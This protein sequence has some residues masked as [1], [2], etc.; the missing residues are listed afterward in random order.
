MTTM[1][2]ANRLVELIKAGQ[3]STAMSELYA[4]DIVSIEAGGEMRESK[5]VEACKGKAEWFNSQFTNN[6]VEIMGPYPNDDKFAIHLTYD[7]TTKEGGQ[8]FKMSEIALYQ[9]KD[10]KIVWE[11][12]YYDPSMM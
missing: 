8:N 7:L 9:V 11:K 4:P 10:G 1:D 5:G 12:F 3:E 2:V 6:G